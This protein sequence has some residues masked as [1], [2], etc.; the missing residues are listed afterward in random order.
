MDILLLASIIK[1]L[2][3][4]LNRIGLHISQQLIVG[5]GQL[6]NLDLSLGGSLVGQ[7]GSLLVI[8][9][10]WGGKGLHLP[11]SYYCL[12]CLWGALPAVPCVASCKKLDHTQ[13]GFRLQHSPQTSAWPFVVTQAPDINTYLGCGMIMDPDMGPVVPWVRHHHG[14][15]L[16]RQIF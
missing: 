5:V 12:G 4:W 2:W 16:Q 8:L 6:R 11:G 10:P 14:L 9:F 13:H 3:L 1:V 7:L 15:R